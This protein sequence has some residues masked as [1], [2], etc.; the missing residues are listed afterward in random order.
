MSLVYNALGQGVDSDSELAAGYYIYDD[1]SEADIPGG[2]G[3]LRAGFIELGNGTRIPTCA[4]V[5]QT[6][7][8]PDF[9]LVDDWFKVLLKPMLI[10]AIILLLISVYRNLK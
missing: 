3:G 1:S 7:H 6:E 9:V 4:G 10:V 5:L 8:L 2:C